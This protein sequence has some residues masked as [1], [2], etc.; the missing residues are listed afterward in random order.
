MPSGTLI[1]R[2]SEP[3]LPRRHDMRTRMRNRT[4]QNQSALIRQSRFLGLVNIPKPGGNYGRQQWG[5]AKRGRRTEQR[6]ADNW[7]L[8]RKL[9]RKAHSRQTDNVIASTWWR[10]KDKQ[11]REQQRTSSDA[12]ISGYRDCVTFPNFEAT[13]YSRAPATKKNK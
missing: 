5:P 9:Q 11:G 3:R 2:H 1:G 4:P 8:I 10:G 7:F 12:L 13:W 6:R